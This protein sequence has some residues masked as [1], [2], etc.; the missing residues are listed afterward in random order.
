MRTQESKDRLMD[1]LQMR[2]DGSTIQ[3]IADKYG[4]TKQCVQQQLS[5]IAGNAKPRPRGIDERVIYPNLAKWI[6]DNRI[7]KYKLSEMIGM[8][9]K[10]TDSIRKKLYGER[11]FTITE[12]KKIIEITGYTFEYIFAEKENNQTE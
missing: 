3:Q 10:C 12:I 1:M 5:I 9:I 8:K 2:L 7:A 6:V 11:D 4:V